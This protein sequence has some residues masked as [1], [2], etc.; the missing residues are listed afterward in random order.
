MTLTSISVSDELQ[1][2]AGNDIVLSSGNILSFMGASLGSSNGTLKAG[3]LAT[4]TAYHL[5]DQ[6]I[7]D[8]GGLTN[9]ASAIGIDSNGVD[10]TDISDDGDTGI[11]DTGD[12]PTITNIHTKPRYDSG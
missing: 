6:N 10:V 2:N 4:Y 3:E 9:S 1:D 11:G 7:V 5:I 8:A 12:D